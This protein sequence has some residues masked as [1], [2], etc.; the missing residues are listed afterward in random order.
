MAYS[1][2]VLADSPI[3]YWKL[4]DSSSPVADDS[5]NGNTGTINGSWNL[6]QTPTHVTG[7]TYGTTSGGGYIVSPAISF[8]SSSVTVEMWAYVNSGQT[9]MP[10]SFG[11]SSLDLYITGGR[12]GFN[13]GA[14]DQYGC[15]IANG[16]HHIVAVVPNNTATTNGKIYIDGALQSLSGS[17]GTAPSLSSCTFQVSGWSASGSYRIP[18]TYYVD[19]VSVYVGELSAGR[20]ATHFSSG[21]PPTDAVVESNYVEA[22]TTESAAPAQV[23]ANYVEVATVSSA[24]PAQVESNY[25]E[26]LQLNA[27]ARVESLY[28]ETLATGTPN[29]QVES[30]YSEA[31]AAGSP[32]IQVEGV[33]TETLINSPRMQTES[34]Y[35]ESLVGGTPGM[36]TESVYAESLVSGMP[37]MQ[38]E[39]VYLEV[40]AQSYP[41]QNFIG[42]GVPI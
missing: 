2:E 6:Q 21:V 32:Y 22:L 26:V 10:F 5:S 16:Y 40:L 25:L 33:Y 20:I 35:A 19:E 28:A 15:S 39:S 1:D 12:I 8:G 31:L 24:A 41:S 23:E 13:T 30:V 14:G 18:S 29:A 36:Q 42:W 11:V 38:T 17:S 37:D 27:A 7:S 34:V 4:D 3:L 9:Y